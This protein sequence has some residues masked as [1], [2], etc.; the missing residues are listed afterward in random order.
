MANFAP[1]NRLIVRTEIKYFLF[2]F[3]SKNGGMCFKADEWRRFCI[4]H[5]LKLNESV[6]FKWRSYFTFD[7]VIYDASGSERNFDAISKDEVGTAMGDN[8]GILDR[9][10]GNSVLTGEDGNVVGVGELRKSSFWIVLPAEI[11][12]D[13]PNPQLIPVVRCNFL[14]QFFV[15]GV[16][17]LT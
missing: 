2:N 7:A 1:G 14:F 15:F 16:C 9:R 13:C 6:V 12:V 11:G 10:C 8:F 4:L 17:E 3:E 5:D